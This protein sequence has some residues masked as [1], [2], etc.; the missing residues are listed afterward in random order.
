LVPATCDLAPRQRCRR[1]P[2]RGGEPPRSSRLYLRYQVLGD[3]PGSNSITRGTPYAA[4]WGSR[5][6]SSTCGESGSANKWLAPSTSIPTSCSPAAKSSEISSVT[7]T[8]TA[9]EVSVH[10]LDIQGIGLFVVTNLHFGSRSSKVIRVDR[11]HNKPIRPQL[12][13]P[14]AGPHTI[15]QPTRAGARDSSDIATGR[16]ERLPLAVANCLGNV[17]FRGSPSGASVPC[18]PGE[19]NRFDLFDHS[20]GMCGAA[21]AGSIFCCKLFP[22]PVAPRSSS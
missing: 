6:F 14:P 8:G 15:C 21:I 1:V 5:C 3:T 2:G 10:Q 16:A 20:F 18:M 4:T 13:A 12:P 11:H 22:L 7:R 19:H 17:R 9:L